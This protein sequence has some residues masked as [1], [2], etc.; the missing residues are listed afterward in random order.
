MGLMYLVFWLTF[1]VGT[2]PMDWIEDGFEWLGNMV[3]SLWPAGSESLLLSLL[4]DGIIA[5]V[6]G[7]VVFL[8]NILLLFLAIAIFR[9]PDPV[10]KWFGTFLLRYAI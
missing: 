6:G 9:L 1:V 2:P 10:G 4:V 8:P 5:G 3:T 7:V